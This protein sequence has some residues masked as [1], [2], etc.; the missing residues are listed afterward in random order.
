MYIY[1]ETKNLIIRELR[2]EDTDGM[3]A[4]DS[5]PDVH[6]YLGNKPIHTKQESIDVI[7]Y[8]RQQY[9]DNG[10]GR[11]A[12][13]DK[14]TNEFVGWTGLKL[15]TT[16]ING[17]TNYYDLGYRLLKKYWG[18]GIA[19]EAAVATLRYAFENLNL[20]EVYAMVDSQN[21]ASNKV[22]K[23]VGFR[24]IKMFI[25][26]RQEHNWYTIRKNDFE[27]RKS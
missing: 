23:K 25:I 14:Q 21:I 9:K 26:E 1:L 10:I 20:L 13:M 3:F 15:I 4:L 8:I 12:I 19:T 22:L 7:H 18:K 2:L 27:N 24:Y 6:Q 16:E 17:L 5:D 11:W